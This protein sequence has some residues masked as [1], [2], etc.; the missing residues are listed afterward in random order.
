MVSALRNLIGW[1]ASLLQ[2]IVCLALN[3]RID[4]DFSQRTT[5]HQESIGEGM[6]LLLRLQLSI[7]FNLDSTHLSP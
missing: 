3:L 4:L 5:A 7:L 1:A 6:N 2:F